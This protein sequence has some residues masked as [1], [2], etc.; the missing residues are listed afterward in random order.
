MILPE[1][2]QQPLQ[3]KF[4]GKVIDNVDPL[5]LGRIIPFV[6]AVP[7]GE[8]NWAMPCVPYA[9]IEVGFY[10]IP[11][12]GANVWIEF[13]GGDPNYPIWVGGFWDEGE[14]PMGAPVPEMKII[15][16]LSNT[17]IM[18]DVPEAGG[19]TLSVLPPAVDD[20]ITVLM[21]SA[22]IQISVPPSE[23]LITPEVITG[24]TPPSVLALSEEA[25][26]IAIPP[27]TVTMS[28][29]GMEV[30]SDE[31]NVTA[32]VTVEGAIEVAGDVEVTGAVEILGDVAVTGA[33]E[34]V[35]DVA[36]AGALELAGDAAIAGALELAG[37]GAIVGAVEIAGDLALAGAQEIVGDLAV[38]GLIEGVVVPP[39]L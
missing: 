29:A 1:Q 33:V 12:I 22:G 32:N 17:L 30:T 6:P 20:P 5:F 26:E 38:A 34:I 10:M 18:S 35:G 25:I 37:D 16:T 31:I 3:G 8:L 9:G 19:V 21:D 36:I 28:E 11:P 4:R 2:I 14:T 39:G 23:V 7:G 15:K 13:E 27:S 24:T